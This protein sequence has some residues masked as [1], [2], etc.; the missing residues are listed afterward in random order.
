MEAVDVA[1]LDIIEAEGQG[2]GL[3]SNGGQ[4][5]CVLSKLPG[6]LIDCLRC[7]QDSLR[8]VLQQED[9]ALDAELLESLYSKVNL[10]GPE[11]VVAEIVKVRPLD[12]VCHCREPFPRIY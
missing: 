9:H 3:N 8:K 1:D 11:G 4:A 5:T 2:H 12:L 10:A 7:I 6:S